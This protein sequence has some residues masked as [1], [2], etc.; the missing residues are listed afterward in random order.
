MRKPAR[1]NWA[2]FFIKQPADR[3]VAS[4]PSEFP[5]AESFVIELAG[6]ELVMRMRLEGGAERAV[7]LSPDAALF[8]REY[9]SVA[10]RR[11]AA[12]GHAED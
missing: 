3:P 9:L 2:D 12:F 10:L 1:Q 11:R 6:E 4:D 8:L 7:R 5:R